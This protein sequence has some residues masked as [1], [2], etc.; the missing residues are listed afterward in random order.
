[1]F[2]SRSRFPLHVAALSSAIVLAACG[3]GDDVVST[4]TIAAAVPAPPADP[5]FVDSAP[6][7]SAPAFV[8]N[9]ATNQRGDARYATL[10]TNA[11]VR[12]LSRFLDLWQP[13]T[14][15]VD[16]GVSA[17]AN[18]AFPAISPST[19]SGLPNSGVSCGTILNDAVLSANVQYVINA[20]TAR[21]PQ[22]A[23]AAYYDDRRGKGYSVT[24]GMGPL[25]AAWRT[26]AQQTTSITSVPA[27]AT[28][29]LYNDSGNNVGVGSSSGNASFGKVVDL[30]NEMGNNASTEPSKR[31][32]KYARPYRWSTSVVVAPTLVP[33]ESTTPATDGGFISGHTAEAVR[34]ATTM[35]WLVPERFQEM[36]SRGL[37]L[38]ENR[39]LAGMHSPLDVIG[40]RMLALAV[41][42]ANLTAYAS[43]A[44]AAYTQAH[45]TLQQLTGTS[46]T[47]FSAFAHSGTTATDRFADYS[48]NQAAFLRRMT[49]GFGAIESTNA[50]PVV[51]KGAEILLQTR[52]PYLS[53]DQRRVVLKT[54]E[55]PSGYPVMDDAE[56][57]GR[58]NLFAA[59]DGYGAFNGNVIVSM[60]ASQGG[61]NAADLWRN[62][63][64]GAGKLTLQ[65]NGTL[66]LAG[67]NSY[68][69]G[70]Q[71]SGGT[72]A[73]ASATAF[74]KGDVYVGSGGGVQI[75]A[76]APVT[77]ATRYTQ[78]DNTTLELD[79]DGN[80]GGRL[81]VGGTLT[82]TGGTLHVK[83]VNGYTPKAGDTIALIDGA[84]AA[85]KF[86]TV[87]VD[88]FKATPVY[89]ATG[90]SITLSA[91]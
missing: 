38:G 61:L 59:A 75:A 27:D 3:G 12:V 26:A 78:L 40:G 65:G 49:F 82:V 41:S 14:M 37:E 45:Q 72:L 13:A 25:T 19:C 20:T 29:V 64:A 9:V 23:D 70:T 11:A 32:F 53:A 51:P 2:A 22:Q 55:L 1:M 17:P 74:G 68:T 77:I 86:S 63:V 50:P 34:D 4:G 85:A 73:A 84:A 71:V 47:T 89:T 31:F 43:D 81:R 5:G 15:L 87:T 52:F 46:A 66:T 88:G 18:G 62:D 30:L 36:I 28:T 69:G 33:A 7:P 44:Q 39:I 6:I 10:S 57:W 54:T 91:A 8:D 48:T 76:N 16:A 21:T 67:N 56:G 58:L 42:A 83:F 24:D 60:D 90:V 80:G 79:I 35:A